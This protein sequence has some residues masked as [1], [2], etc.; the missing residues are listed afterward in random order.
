MRDSAKVNTNKLTPIGIWLV[1]TEGEAL[2]TLLQA[3]LGATVHRPWL[4]AAVPHKAQFAAVYRQHAQW[5]MIAAS[6]SAA[7][8]NAAFQLGTPK[9]R[10]GWRMRTVCVDRL[11]A[12]KISCA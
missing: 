2:A 8:G 11:L 4:N 12:R 6:G 7:V 10:T 3:Q 1:R 5:V 9:R